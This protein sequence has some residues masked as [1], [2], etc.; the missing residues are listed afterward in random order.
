MRHLTLLAVALVVGCATTRPIA[1]P[2]PELTVRKALDCLYANDLD[3]AM[4]LFHVPVRT[5]EQMVRAELAGHTERMS[6]GEWS[7]EII[8]S[9]VTGDFAVVIVNEKGK[10]KTRIDL[11]PIYLLY[12]PEGW[13]L[14]P[15]LTDYMPLVGKK[16]QGYREFGRLK[17]WFKARKEALMKE[18]G[19]SRGH[20]PGMAREGWYG[21]RWPRAWPHPS[22]FCVHTSAFCIAALP[23][24]VA[25]G[26][27][28]RKLDE[29]DVAV[30]DEILVVLEKERTGLVDFLVD[31]GAG[32]P[33]EGDVVL[34][35]RAVEENAQ[36][37]GVENGMVF[38]AAGRAEGDVVALPLRGRQT[39]IGQGRRLVVDGTA[40]ARAGD[41][42]AVGIEHLHLVAALQENTAVALVLTGGLG[43][44]RAA[45]FEVEEEVGEAGLGHDIARTGDDMEDAVLVHAPAGGLA[46][47]GGPASEIGI[48]EEADG[49]LGGI[50]A[51]GDKHGLESC[52]V[53]AW[54]SIELLTR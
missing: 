29:P 10:Q 38:P 21:L 13:K 30:A 25:V 41:V 36:A 44:V 14:S 40:I 51:K 48:V 15:E 33:G 7:H 37:G 26:T 9:K 2:S 43:H 27:G 24:F 54:P 11:D 4:A 39:G 28:E 22:P 32:H 17:K 50:G 8:E 18:L 52:F 6:T 19:A 53:A 20:S 47:A 16:G 46:L 3:G 45:E 12:T 31:G 42:D 5:T 34:D 1:R 23:G 49:I 35:E